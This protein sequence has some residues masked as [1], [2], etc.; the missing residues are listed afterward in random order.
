MEQTLTAQFFVHSSIFP[1]EV[2]T[3]EK[4]HHCNNHW[5]LSPQYFTINRDSCIDLDQ[6]ESPPLHSPHKA[7]MRAGRR[8]NEHL[9]GT[10]WVR[11]QGGWRSDKWKLF[12]ILFVNVFWLREKLKEA[13]CVSVCLFVWQ[14]IYQGLLIFMSLYLRYLSGFSK[15]SLRIGSGLFRVCLRSVT[16]LLYTIPSYSKS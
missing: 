8:E 10:L 15:V 12:S 2:V 5:F 4:H 11:R 13:L 14:K 16:T 9:T 7:T 1:W 6:P 3:P